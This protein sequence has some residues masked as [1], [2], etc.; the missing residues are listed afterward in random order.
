M[1]FRNWTRDHSKGLIIGFFSPLIFI[2][3]V[4]FLLAWSRNYSFNELWNMF[5]LSHQTMSKVLSL[6]II[7]N[8]FWFYFFLN[9]NKYGLAMGIILG[10]LAY[11]PYIFY[12]NLVL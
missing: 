11:F 10:T 12:V 3:L 5:L 8:L 4:I 7:S 9:R 6:S 2:P 1:N